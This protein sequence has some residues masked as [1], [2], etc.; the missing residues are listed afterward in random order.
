VLNRRQF[1][2][3]SAGVLAGATGCTSLKARLT[4]PPDEERLLPAEGPQ[5]FRIAIFSDPHT[6][7]TDASNAGAINGKLKA[8]V[9]AYKSLRPDLWLV[10]GDIADDGRT[11]QMEAFKKVMAAVAKPD[12][13]LVNTGNHD[14]YD[15]DASDDEELRRFREAFGLPAA[16]SSRVAGGL[17]IVMLANE[18]HKS[19]PRYREWAWL[20]PAQLKW[21][22]RVLAEHR[23]KFTVVCLHQPLQDTVVW[24]WGGND[25][26]G[27]GQA[28]ELRAILAKNPQVRLW[29]SGHT[30]MGA[31]VAGN[32]SGQGR[33]TFVGLG[34]TFYQFVQSDVATEFGNFRKDLSVSQSRLLEVWPDRV[35][36]RARDHVARAWMEENELVL[37]RT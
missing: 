27:C 33:V 21:F 11:E 4:P 35:V 8:G 24:S 1:L 12:Q 9:T 20:S 17:H 22:E 7:S 28:K 5:P 36:L 34:S 13:L 37:K 19:A 2:I 25:F 32:V 3:S 29:L 18:L 26:A 23:E 15:Q 16:Y 6:V 10:N 30:H 14:F 31:E